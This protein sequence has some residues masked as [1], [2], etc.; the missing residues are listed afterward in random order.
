MQPTPA[1]VS[2][3]HDY[4]SGGEM[5]PKSAEEGRSGRSGQSRLNVPARTWR[6]KDPAM[7]EELFQQGLLQYRD[8]SEELAWSPGR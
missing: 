3:P 6:P 5:V 2:V 4:A 7:D 8:V 1:D